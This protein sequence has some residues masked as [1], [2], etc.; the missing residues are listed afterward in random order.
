M[1]KYVMLGSAAQA[2][3]SALV[4]VTGL[5]KL[6]WEQQLIAGLLFLG[7]VVILNLRD[8]MRRG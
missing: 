5:V 3:A 6:G 7:A 4:A 2:F 1:G 8:E